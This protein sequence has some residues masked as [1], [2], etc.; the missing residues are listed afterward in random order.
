MVTVH[1]FTVTKNY[2]RNF[3]RNLQKHLTNGQACD[4]LISVMITIIVTFFF[5]LSIT[6]SNFFE[7]NTANSILTDHSKIC[8]YKNAKNNTVP[9]KNLKVVFL[10]ITHQKLD[11]KHGNKECH[12]TTHRQYPPFH[13]THINS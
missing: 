12:N 6:F 3:R 10:N 7:T 11:N 1:T 2:Q 9:S 5:F 4:K 13:T 8:Q